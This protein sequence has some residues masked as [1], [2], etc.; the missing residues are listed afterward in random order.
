MSVARGT[1]GRLGPAERCSRIIAKPPSE[2]AVKAWFY[3]LTNSLQQ[4][5]NNEGSFPVSFPR[6]I[7]DFSIKLHKFVQR[8]AVFFERWLHTQSEISPPTRQMTK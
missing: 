1:H 6:R 8:F 5:I 3:N 2:S 4:I 7:F